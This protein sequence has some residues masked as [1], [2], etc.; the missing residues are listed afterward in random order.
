MRTSFRC[1]PVLACAVWAA[2]ACAASGPPGGGEPPPVRIAAIDTF[3]HAPGEAPA[4]WLAR[5]P[6]GT[7]TMGDGVAAHGRARVEVT[8]TRDYWLGQCEVTNREFLEMLQWAHDR[9]LVWADA[10]VVVDWT[11]GAETLLMELD[12]EWCEIAYDQR[13]GRFV[14][15]QGPSRHAHAA[16]PD[17]YDPADHPVKEVTYEGSLAFCDWLNRRAGLPD[18]YDHVT[19]EARDG[20]PAAAAGYRLP[21]EAEWERA[22]RHPDGRIRPWGDAPCDASRANHGRGE[23]G[24]TTPVASFAGA[25]VIAGQPFHDLI[26]NLHERVH[27]WYREY[28]PG[29]RL[30]DPTGPPAGDR[31]P[32]KGDSWWPYSR[33]PRSA[34]RFPSFP[35]Y[36]GG[37]VGFRIARTVTAS[38]T[39]SGPPEARPWR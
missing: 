11:G 16:Y 31:R 26:G 9:G 30:V 1:G 39:G 13:S 33:D 7:F 3:L 24:W 27:G 22:A 2:T 17:G 35:G 21:T 10:Y 28:A 32:L 18:V 34:L 6:A 23:G 14:L 37:H 38:Q 29:E 5:V 4:C 20:D 12:N 19:W 25:P 15:R 36:R 8:L